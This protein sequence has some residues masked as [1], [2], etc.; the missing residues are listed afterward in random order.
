MFLLVILLRIDCYQNFVNVGGMCGPSNLLSS[1]KLL[2]RAGGPLSFMQR[3]I[4]HEVLPTEQA[5]AILIYSCKVV[6]K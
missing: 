5:T 6:L 2:M 1:S 3:L 4:H